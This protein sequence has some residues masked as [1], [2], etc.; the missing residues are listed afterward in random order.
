MK[1]L[2]ESRDIL[3]LDDERYMEH[4]SKIEA[5]RLGLEKQYVEAEA[6]FNEAGRVRFGP[7]TECMDADL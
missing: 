1:G 2:Q 6:E 5:H 7:L 3:K 4:L